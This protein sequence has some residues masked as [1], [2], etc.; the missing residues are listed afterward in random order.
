M[1]FAIEQILVK[2]VITKIEFVFGPKRRKVP[3]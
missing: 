3:I 2:V 1:E